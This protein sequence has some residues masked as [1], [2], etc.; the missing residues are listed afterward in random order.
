[1]SNH[2]TIT[3]PVEA[4]DGKTYFRRVGALFA[5]KEDSKTAFNIKMDFPVGATEF[6]VFAPKDTPPEEE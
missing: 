3:V 6:A 2:Y 4:K 5:S 1:M